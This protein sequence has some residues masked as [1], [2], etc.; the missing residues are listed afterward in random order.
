MK[1]TNARRTLLLL[2]LLLLASQINNA[3]TQEPQLAQLQNDLA[4]RFLEPAPHMALARY[5]LDHGNRLEAFYTLESARRGRFEEK[6]FNRAF[7]LAFR[8]FDNSNTAEAALLRARARDPQSVEI[9]FQLADIYISREEWAKAKEVLETALHKKPDDFRFITGLE[10]V[11][12]REGKEQEAL[13]LTENY[14]RT[15]PDPEMVYL[16]R[17]EELSEKDPAQAKLILTEAIAEF[18]KSGYLLFRLGSLVQ[19]E[20]DLQKAEEALVRAAELAPDS[21]YIQAWTGRFFFKVKLDNGAALVYYLNAY[22]LDPHTYETEFVESRIRKIAMEVAEGKLKEKIRKRVA[23]I[24]ILADKDPNVV[25]LAL[26]QISDMW[27]P[28]YIDKLVELMGHDD[29]SIRWQASQLLKKNVDESFDNKL[30]A[31]LN[32]AD[33]RKRGLAAYIAVSRWKN[34]SFP[35]INQLLR[36]QAQLLRF[37]ALS[38]LMIDGGSE[39]RKLAFAHAARETNPTLKKLIESSKNK[40]SSSP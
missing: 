23:L 30:K 3:Q 28:G 17:A 7:L 37:D 2:A 22:F 21:S 6:T 19:R 8:G 34:A 25:L 18:P 32:D 11:L 24:D 36:E 1:L 31:L 39:G 14:R 9:L 27:H 29:Q 16:Q 15:H 13:R 12:K 5:Y 4:M 35:F 20:G 40:G 38:A 10:E 26:G 33:L